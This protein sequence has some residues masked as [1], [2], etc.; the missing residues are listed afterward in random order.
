MKKF[1]DEQEIN[2]NLRFLKQLAKSFPTQ[3]DAMTE[4]VNLSSILALPKPTEHFM[5]DLHGQGDAFEHILNNCS[6]VIRNEITR[7]FKDELSFEEMETLATIV[8]Y[9]RQKIAL[10]LNSREGDEDRWLKQTLRL[11]IQLG[12]KV[13]SKYTRSRVRK[14]IDPRYAYI[15]DE[16]L[17]ARINFHDLDAYYNEIFD[18]IIRYDYAENV[19]V[20]LTDTIKRLAVERMHIVG[21]IYDRGPEPHRILDLLLEHPSVDIQWGNHDILWMGAAM[22]D[23]TCISGV[24]TN[25]FRHGNLELI[26]DVYG[27][28]LRHLLMFAQETYKSAL[29]FRPRKT[30]VDAYYDNPEINIR[31]KLHK[32][33]FV[34]MHKLEGQMIKRNPNFKLD[35]RLLLEGINKEHSTITIEG[36][37]YPIK[38]AD[39]PTIDPKDPYRLTDEEQAIIDELQQSFLKSPRLQKHMRFFI[40]RGSM[41]LVVNNNLLYHALV[42]MNED[43]TFKDVELGGVA[44]HGKELFDYL[45]A[46]VKRIYH[47]EPEERTAD[48]LDLMWYLWCGPD[49]PFFGKNKMTTFERVEIDDSKTHKE[50]RNAYYSYQDTEDMAVSI[51]HEFGIENTENSVIVN[52]HIPVEKINGENPIK[53]NGK[54]IVIDGGF[55]RYYQKTTGIAGYTLTYD[56]RGLYIVAHEPF[57]SLQKAIEDNADIK[58]TID[59]QDILATKGQMTVKDT[60]KGAE[61][62]DEI[63]SL[64]MLV[65][66]YEYGIIKENHSTK[67]VK[68]S[69]AY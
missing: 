24:L 38:D 61:L 69:T 41:Y 65:Q 39:F 5:S 2:E 58:A 45:D 49:S 47:I 43:G 52:G 66:A 42:P 29:V 32:A 27:I 9:P 53:A 64:E 35:H 8:Y 21:D 3:E 37:S 46:E 31:A 13:S 30:S 28:N 48:E 11:L 14:S 67:L 44:R 23:K 50:K 16:L 63:H 54:L 40:E 26:E 55:S 25:S 19:I 57:V 36:A 33:I 12:R 10:E 6:G 4:I 62:E 68:V 20:A 15:I 60:D 17:T 51:M 56:S 59:V 34:I 22:G 18:S 1:I 7:L